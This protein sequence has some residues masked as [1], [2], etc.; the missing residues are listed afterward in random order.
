[1]LHFI[2]S[3]HWKEVF[4]KQ[5]FDTRMSIWMTFVIVLISKK[6]LE[7]IILEKNL[8]YLK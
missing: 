8:F 7:K 1:M 3:F 4:L 6:R 5:S 2:P